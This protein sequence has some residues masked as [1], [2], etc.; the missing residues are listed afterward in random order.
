MDPVGE[1]AQA[2][3]RESW[4]RGAVGYDHDAGHGL[5]TPAV[6]EAWSAALQ[7][8][9]GTAPL[10][11][12]D[13]GTGTGFLAVIAAR[14]GHRVTG[15]DLTPAMLE[16]AHGRSAEAGVDVD[17]QE[18]DAAALPFPD[19]SFDAVVSRHVVWTMT[20]PATAFREWARVARPGGRVIWYD[21]LEPSGVRVALRQRL[22]RVV[23]LI[24][25][26][27]DHLSDHSYTPEAIAALP[28]HGARTTE[29]VEALLRGLGVEEVSLQTLTA[30]ARAE[31]HDEPLAKRLAG[32]EPRYVGA[33]SVSGELKEQLAQ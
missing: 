20:D 30:V 11:V 24:Q 12:L 16:R 21:G 1:R 29:P 25:R 3:I 14:L 23:G 5:A 31:M 8:E 26:V 13:V 28:L 33:F 6:E 9:L 2:A 19:S 27:Q 4:T 17:W 32:P 10:A 22:G 18:G 15:I 7:E